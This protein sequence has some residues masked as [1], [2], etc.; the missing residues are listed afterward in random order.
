MQRCSCCV[1][2]LFV[3]H[4]SSKEWHGFAYF[5]SWSFIKFF[6]LK[7]ENT[8]HISFS[9]FVSETCLRF[10]K[11]LKSNWWCRMSNRG[12][13]ASFIFIKICFNFLWSILFNWGPIK[14]VGWLLIVMLSSRW[15][16]NVII[17]SRLISSSCLNFGIA[18][19]KIKM[20]L[21]WS[22]DV[23]FPFDIFWQHLL[24]WWLLFIQN[25]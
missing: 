20:S 1:Q 21:R 4:G 22:I 7:I 9:N 11:S 13:R 12:F 17:K 5:W 10:S 2:Y 25:F 18:V 14:R 8:R 15:I 6:V 24:W 19:I 23:L 16:L 3:C